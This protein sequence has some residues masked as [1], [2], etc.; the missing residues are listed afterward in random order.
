VPR[1]INRVGGS[2]SGACGTAVVVLRH[3]ERELMMLPGKYLIGRSRS[4]QLI[5]SSELVSRRHAELHVDV[6]GGVTLRD[7]GSH[8][9]VSVNGKRMTAGSVVLES[10]DQFKIGT[11][12]FTV[13]ISADALDS[14]SMR[15][16]EVVTETA[17]T[18]VKHT[19]VASMAE[20][21][22]THDL[23]LVCSA[24]DRA[25]DFGAVSEA[26]R[27]LTIH[28]NE[29]LA[30]I[31]TLQ[32]TSVA[33]RNKAFDYALRLAAVT[34]KQ[35]WFD[36]AIDVLLAQ[37]VVATQEQAESL[38]HAQ[39]KMERLDT[40][41]VELYSRLVRR[42][43]PTTENLRVAALLEAIVAAGH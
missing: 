25:I 15:V 24:A 12:T 13:Y 1:E 9:G 10:G 38:L 35:Q 37:G 14:A 36:Y 28:L 42:K 43:S 22:A 18:E 32:R 40:Q 2:N 11:D 4:C 8:N 23:D 27:I 3:A 41:R 29:V 17:P 31:R 20:T 30:D 26:E 5:V 34:Q 33:I 19:A 39:K 21:R 16:V 7:L 6:L